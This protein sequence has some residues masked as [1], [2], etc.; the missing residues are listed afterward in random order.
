MYAAAECLC[1]LCVVV[2]C[3]LCAVYRV[4]FDRSVVTHTH[5]THQQDFV[6]EFMKSNE[7][8]EEHRDK[9]RD[10]IKD[11]VRAAKQKQRAAKEEKQAR[12]T[13]MSAQE[14]D[15]LKT[16]SVYKFYP[17]NKFPDIEKYKARATGCMRSC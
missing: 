16:M 15:A 13:A 8:D 17:Q 1:V 5:H 10:Q 9:L 12:V 3:G 4:C 6:D 11:E 2:C 14:R 7:L